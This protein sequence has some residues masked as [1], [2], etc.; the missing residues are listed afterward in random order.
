MSRAPRPACCVPR[1][2][3]PLL[4][5]LT[6]AL[7]L[8]APPV[9]SQDVPAGC[10]ELDGASALLGVVHEPRAG[11][12]LPSAEVYL[13][14]IVEER[15]GPDTTR[16]RTDQAARFAFCDLPPGSTVAVWAR[17]SAGESARYG[18][19]LPA[20]SAVRVDLPVPLAAAGRLAGQV[21]DRAS[22]G[23]IEGA[24]LELPDLGVEAV[25]NGRGE[26]ILP[27]VPGGHHLLRIRHLAYGEREDSVRV[28]PTKS[29]R[30]VLL[31]ES[32]PIALAPLE[33][34]VEGVRPTWLEATGFYRRMSRTGGA[35]ITREDIEARDPERVSQMLKPIS[36]LRVRTDGNIAML[37]APRSLVTGARCQVQYFVDGRRTILPIGVD[38]FEPADVEAIEVYRGPSEL[39]AF[40]DRGRAACGAVVL[41]MR[42]ER[43]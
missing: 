43:N 25:T 17:H 6:A 28:P 2:F 32:E 12:P 40:F 31:L 23:G 36:G 7:V 8:A 42:V 35:F 29:V 37:R 41:W 39:P 5:C 38:A 33:V 30:L 34:Q 1:R 24:V 15:V 11:T 18:V 22:G 9:T 4:T 14:P 10:P 27:P 3:G 21:V 16:V 13:A 20:D 19:W 26:F